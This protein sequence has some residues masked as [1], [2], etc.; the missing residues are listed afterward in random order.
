MN[1]S[2]TVVITGAS[3][4]IGA[5]L[6]LGCGRAGYRVVVN[7]LER[8]VEASQ[9]VSKIHG[10]GG[11][12]FSVKAD[13]RD[14]QSVEALFQRVA[15]EFGECHCLV[16]NAHTPFAPTALSELHWEDFQHQVDGSLKS[17]FLCCKAALPLLQKGGAILNMSSVTVRKPALGF[18]HRSAVKGAVEALTRNL[19]LEL[20]DRKVRVNALSIGWTS[21]DQVHGIGDGE[22]RRQVDAIPL[23][24]LARPE[25]IADTALFLLSERASFITGMVFPVDGGADGVVR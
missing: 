4:G 17:V 12:A 3:R 6:A 2:Q 24:R 25:E 22:R 8:E 16:N 14:P 15:R 13:V 9:T 23:G 18:C 21:T 10:L 11:Q 7:Y 19:A 20:A 5:A 1:S